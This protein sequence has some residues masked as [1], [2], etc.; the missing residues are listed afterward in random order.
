MTDKEREL[1]TQ[2]L[3]LIT[4]L[5]KE[6]LVLEMGLILEM[7]EALAQPEQEQL[8]KD[9]V[10]HGMTVTLGGKRIDPSSI[11]KEPEPPF[12][13]SDDGADTNIT[14]GL[15]PKGEGLVTL[16]QREWVGLTDA[17]LM[18]EFGYTD[19]LLRDT[20]YRVEKILAGRNT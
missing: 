16:H 15:E 18:K 14:R 1:F 2:A 4:E 3:N 17:D 5:D 6:G 13:L 11:Y 12:K 7:R 10:T 19:E 8:I 9:Y 20:A